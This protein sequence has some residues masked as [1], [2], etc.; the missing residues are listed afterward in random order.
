MIQRWIDFDASSQGAHDLS[1]RFKACAIPCTRRIIEEQRS[2]GWGIF[3][4]L[5]LLTRCQT[6]FFL[7]SSPLCASPLPF[8]CKLLCW[9]NKIRCR[10][11][12]WGNNEGNRRSV[13]IEG[14]YVASWFKVLNG[15]FISINCNEMVS[16]CP[17]TMRFHCVAF[18]SA[19]LGQN[20]LYLE[21]W[22][23]L[24]HGEIKI[25]VHFIFL[26]PLYLI[27]FSY[28]PNP[29]IPIF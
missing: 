22:M 17:V 20:Q 23:F 4:G 10:H 7:T 2:E 21:Y 5:P 27:I 26:V 18:A 13:Q 11:P 9:I 19:H 15:T 14:S 16:M 28:R 29:H 8:A 25:T 1:R 6:P 24:K 12:K 3:G